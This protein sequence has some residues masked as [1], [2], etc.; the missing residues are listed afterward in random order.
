MAWG[1]QMVKVRDLTLMQQIFTGHSVP[2]TGD[3]IRSKILIQLEYF[4]NKR[5]HML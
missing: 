3:R 2:D 5:L 4:L 1:E